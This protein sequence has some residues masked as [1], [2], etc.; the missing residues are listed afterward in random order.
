MVARR[1]TGCGNNR[2]PD[3]NPRVEETL[4]QIFEKKASLLLAPAGPEEGLTSS[5]QFRS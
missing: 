2:N 5:V 3:E 1:P 4:L